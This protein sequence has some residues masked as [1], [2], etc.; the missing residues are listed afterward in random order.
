MVWLVISP[1]LILL[2]GCGDQPPAEEPCNFV[3][4]KASRRVSWAQTPIRFY[5]DDSISNVQFHDIREAMEV[6]NK[7]FDRPVFELIGRTNQLPDPV[8]GDDGRMAPDSFNG[9]YVVDAS[10]FENTSQRDEQARTSISF[11]GDF[12]YEADILIDASENLHFED[13]TEV[14]QKRFSGAKI[15]FKSLMV[16]ELGHVLGLDHIDDVE[17]SVMDSRLEQGEFRVEIA[18]VDAASLACEY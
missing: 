15:H 14:N 18:E 12:I 8:L 7:L 3:Q 4:N 17:G 10:A 11:R 9:I 13:P 6:W 1:L 2:T 16:H 5:A